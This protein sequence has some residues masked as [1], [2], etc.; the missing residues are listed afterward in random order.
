M[1]THI[2]PLAGKVAFTD[3]LI[4]VDKLVAAYYARTTR[5]DG[6]HA[7]GSFWHLRSPRIGF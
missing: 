3:Q 5:P 6:A 7:A 2:S 1:T 4:N